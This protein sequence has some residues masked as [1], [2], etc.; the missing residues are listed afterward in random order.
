[1]ATVPAPILYCS[2]SYP[3]D[4]SGRALFTILVPATMFMAPNALNINN[5]FGSPAASR[6]SE[7]E[8]SIALATEYF[9]P[10]VSLLKFMWKY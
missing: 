10:T 4:V 7:P 9:P 5:E 3:K 2:F 6:V 1:L 8:I